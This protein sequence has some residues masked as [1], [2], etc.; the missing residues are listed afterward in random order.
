MGDWPKIKKV[1][2]SSNVL[3]CSMT[4]SFLGKILIHG[5]DICYRVD[6]NGRITFT[7]IKHVPQ[8]LV[9]NSCTGVNEN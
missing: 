4:A 3:I 6:I 8:L 1:K 9:K 7:K 5:V 2:M